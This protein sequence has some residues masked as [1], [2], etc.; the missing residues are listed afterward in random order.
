MNSFCRMLAVCL[1]FG[2]LVV[3]A[4]SLAEK[5]IQ[6]EQLERFEQ[7]IT[8]VETKCGVKVDAKIDF[9]SFKGVERISPSGYCGYGLEQV[10]TVCG[11]EDGKKAVAAKLKSFRCSY[12]AKKRD[13]A[14]TGGTLKYTPDANGTQDDF[15]KK[16]L[17]EHL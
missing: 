13:V 9:S 15:V 14:F 5:K 2:S 7:Y 10:A 6:K 3:R 11:D 17:M 12:N 8:E 1:V 4:E 16:Y